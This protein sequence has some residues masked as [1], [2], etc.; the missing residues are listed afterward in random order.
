[1]TEGDYVYRLEVSE[2]AYKLY[3]DNKT[4]STEVT[5]I[6]KI[7]SLPYSSNFDCSKT[8]S[9]SFIQVGAFYNGKT[10]GNETD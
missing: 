6:T 10:D 5:A 3:K 2:S 8:K 7:D 4:D 9:H 1:M